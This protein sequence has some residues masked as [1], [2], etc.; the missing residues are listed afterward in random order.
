MKSS[1]KLHSLQAF[2]GFF[3]IMVLLYHL[4]TICLQK[5]H[6][7]P[8]YGLMEWAYGSLEFFFILSGFVIYYVHRG[9]IGHPERFKSYATKRLIRIY[10][11]YWVVLAAVLPVYFLVPSFGDQTGRTPLHLIESIFLLPPRQIGQIVTVAWTLSY[12]M[13]FY[14][15]FG[16]AIL[17]SR[18]A[19]MILVSTIAAVSLFFFGTQMAHVTAFTSNSVVESVF[20]FMNIDLLLGVLAA[21]IVWR[22]G[23]KMPRAVLAVG[24]VLFLLGAVLEVRLRSEFPIEHRLASFAFAAFL[25]LVGAVTL[26]MQGRLSF[27]WILQYLG[28]ASYSIY[29]TH[30]ILLS[31][32]AKVLLTLHAFSFLGVALNTL[33]LFVLTVGSGVLTYAF[34]EFPLLELCRRT[35][36]PAKVKVAV[37]AV[38]PET[39]AA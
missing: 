26:E 10:P 39:A 38:A 20:S 5:F 35:F 9:D 29:I 8:S 27:P 19:S 37:P 18:R 23:V 31:M 25:V 15:I 3:T 14:V 6:Y 30:F 16:I 1:P 34:V 2:R 7:D 11:I 28:E 17:I 21:E 24:V 22:G 13:W 4:K 12:E 33:L 32:F 36:L